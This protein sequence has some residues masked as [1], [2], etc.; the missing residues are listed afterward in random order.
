M[1][2]GINLKHIT[3]L[4]SLLLVSLVAK[5][6]TW[7]D[8]DTKYTWSYRDCGNGVEI[9][10]NAGCAVSPRPSGRITV[11][12]ELGGKTVVSIG[13]CAFY[14]CPDLKGIALPN[15]ITNIGR[16]AFCWSKSINSITIPSSVVSIGW[17]AFFGCNIESVTVSQYIC[18][19]SRNDNDLGDLF[20]KVKT[21]VVPEGVK[22]IGDYA[23][24]DSYYLQSIV[25][26]NGVDN[27]GD[28]AF[29][30]C[31]NLTKVTLPNTVTNIGQN[32]FTSCYELSDVNIP[33]NVVHIGK[34][35]FA[36]CNETIFDT[37]SIPNAKLIN[38]WVVE[39]SSDISGNPNLTDVVGIADSSFASRRFLSGVTVPNGVRYIGNNAFSY[40]R[41]L[42]NV[43]INDGVIHLGDL[44]FN[45]SGNLANVTFL[46]HVPQNL[47]AS[48]ICEYATS[49]RFPKR[50]AA[51]Y[52]SIIPSYKFGGFMYPTLADWVASTD[53]NFISCDTS[54]WV[55]DIEVSH[56]GDE[57]LR[58][59]EVGNNEST[60]LEATVNGAGRLSFWWKASSEEYEGEIYDY[61][62]LSVDGVAQGTLNGD[63]L[64]GIAI[65]G[66]TD[67]TNV[68]LDVVG[69]GSHA[70][71]WTYCKD[72]SD[73]CDVGDDCVWLDEFSFRSKVSVSFDV[74]NGDGAPPSTIIALQGDVVSFPTGE[75]VP[76]TDH[77]FGGWTD[78]ARDYAAGAD[79][80]VP[81]T[82]VTLTAIWIAKRFL[83]FTLDGGEGEIPVT[84][85]DVPDA[86]V[87]L[88]SADGISK[89]KYHFV[90]WS[91]GTQTYEA[92]AE[93]VVTDSG[94]EFTAVWAANTLDAPVISSADV[95]DG[96]TIETE[97]A[98][99]EIEA[100]DGAAIYYTT[101][102]TEP[103]T[104]S[105]LYTA[106]FTAD[107]MSVTIK[108]FA[109]K[110]DYFDSAV[111]EFS[112]TRKPHSAAECLN[113][114][115]KTVST[116]GTDA[117]WERVLG[118][119]A[120][121]GVA[122]LR[123]G[124]IGEGGSSTVEMSVDGAGEIG[125][126]WKTSC[127]TAAK[128][129]Q[130]DFAA[131]YLDGTEQCWMGGITDWSNKVFTVS[132][133]GAHSLK[134][135][136][137]KNENNTTNGEDC[138]WLDEVKWTPWREITT[139]QTAVP[140][141]YGWFES[142]G[143]LSG[144]SNPESVA[145]QT[146]GKRDGSGRLLTVMDDFIA[147]T[148]PTDENDVFS[149]TISISN[150]LPVV[151]W[152]PNLNTNGANRVYTIYGKETLDDDWATPTNALSHFFK[153]DVA[154]P[155]T[156]EGSGAAGGG[157]TDGDEPTGD[158]SG[159]SVNQIPA[160]Y[161]T[162]N[163]QCVSCT[164]SEWYDLGLP[165]TLTMKTQIK[166][167]FAGENEHMA[168]IGVVQPTTQWNVDEYR[169]FIAATPFEW[170]LD[171]PGPSR[172]HGTSVELN[173]VREVE[174]GN[175]YV[176]DMATDTVLLSGDTVTKACPQ[177]NIRL[178]RTNYSY[179]NRYT[180][181]SVYYVKIYDL[182]AS[183]EYE[184]VRNLV[185]C[186]PNDGDVGLLDLVEM[187]FY[188]NDGTSVQLAN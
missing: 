160:G 162:N 72:G 121:D 19:T 44:A 142:H 22:N 123:S 28:Y 35:A 148:D 129:T 42:S 34:A 111:A 131:F 66:K 182:K 46:G 170:F 48:T 27:I 147:G 36:N 65:G 167:S 99:I 169:L 115:G 135:V 70:I 166:C 178:F 3:Q 127:E 156:A 18:A 29:G 93:Y 90:G 74:A 136:Y 120:H 77:V 39:T 113:V 151:E 25:L 186:K 104:N 82:N 177:N 60:W 81:A 33:D 14:S 174:F 179:P 154:M 11:P 86:T 67:W 139:K 84:I 143:L 10:D 140:I 187:K 118:D 6:D 119:S 32:A 53:V 5:A 78:G 55:G 144:D 114:N 112:F 102:G 180:T 30:Y 43:T 134:W 176:K 117:K 63:K 7:T 76:L 188:K 110:D 17:Q 145:M 85:K 125:F 124:A 16:Q 88:P 49:V 57:S 87:T 163:V 50:F 101:D 128:N 146:T 153:V 98:T 97:S 4:C 12:L 184:L 69:D 51:S 62:Y 45:E 164:G 175:F 133:D 61:A 105:A 109:V 161:S 23:F 108:A 73:E 1:R 58:S 132:G 64:N 165:P 95:V 24:Y 89:P 103:T 168:I 52:G 137:R 15:T 106:P 157:S 21:I 138:A 31:R 41:N 94:V 172:I 80:T 152:H 37:V 75:G 83:T 40:C 9:F 150:G 20:D 158:E 59:G 38:H 2:T 79:Y 107:G 91:D 173:E 116:G 56:D 183:N 8:P 47:L 122:A 171:L 92:G 159:E 149:V 100:T 126:W 26:P 71:R 141:P 68:V 130:R 13:D 96:G 54:Q 155:P 185:P 181:G